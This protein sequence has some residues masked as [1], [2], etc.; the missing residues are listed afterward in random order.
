MSFVARADRGVRYRDG[1]VT[2][3]DMRLHYVDYGGSGEPVVALPGLF[4]NA[5]AFDAISH[6]IPPGR[7]LV[8]LDMRGRGGSDWAPPD[9]YSWSWYLRDLQRAL[10]TLNLTPCA[11]IGTSIGGA[12]AMLHAMARPTQVTALVMNDSSLDANAAGVARATK[13]I[14]YAPATFASLAEASAWFASHRDGLDR[15]DDSSRLAWVSHFLTPAP[16]GGLRFNCDPALIRRARLESPDSGPRVAWAHRWAA[17]E[18]LE[19]LR[20]PVLLLRG[21]MSDV[22]PR[23]TA[24]RMV[25]ALP[26]ARW[27]EVPGVGHAPTL[28]EPEALEALRVFFAGLARSPHVTEIVASL[29]ESA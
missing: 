1:Y 12:L 2:L 19:R 7:R 29:Q 6:V 9:T 10:T 20:M 15:L 13:R 23:A 22:V 8:A 25:G 24:Q 21:E 28:Y 18:R 3:A 11:L 26:D 14:G 4:Q 5:H 27:W 16:G 17:W